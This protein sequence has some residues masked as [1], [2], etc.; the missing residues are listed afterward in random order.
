[1]DRGAWR[2]TVPRVAKSQTQLSLHAWTHKLF[3]V[4]FLFFFALNSFPLFFSL[5]LNWIPE[6]GSSAQSF[7]EYQTT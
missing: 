7:T 5:L 4:C 2:A 6:L 3:F 1:M